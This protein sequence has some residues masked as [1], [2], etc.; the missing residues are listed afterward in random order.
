MKYGIVVSV[1]L[2]LISACKP[3]ARQEPVSDELFI[4]RLLMNLI[5]NIERSK[6]WTFRCIEVLSN[7]NIFTEKEFY[8]KLGHLEDSIYTIKK[9]YTWNFSNKI[10]EYTKTRGSITDK[11]KD[12][13]K[14]KLRKDYNSFTKEAKTEFDEMLDSS[15]FYDKS[16][17]AFAVN[18]WS[19]NWRMRASKRVNDIKKDLNMLPDFLTP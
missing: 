12:L 3:I 19:G 13:F 18:L 5:Y 7:D 8:K 6:R 15:E 2:V 4:G 16:E 1:I 10:E 9:D 17:R 11:K 14:N